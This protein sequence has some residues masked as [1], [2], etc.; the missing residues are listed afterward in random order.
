MGAASPIGGALSDT[1]YAYK[2]TATSP[3]RVYRSTY[4]GNSTPL[5]ALQVLAAS[6]AVLHVEVQA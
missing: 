4:P 1:N 5:G 3:T 2:L 6:A